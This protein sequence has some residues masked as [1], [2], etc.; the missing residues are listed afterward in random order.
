MQ[1][2]VNIIIPAIGMITTSI[3]TILVIVIVGKGLL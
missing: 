2:M 1:T 3:G